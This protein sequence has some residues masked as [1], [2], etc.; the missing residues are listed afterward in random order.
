MKF[1]IGTSQSMVNTSVSGSTKTQSEQRL[2]EAWSV[3]GDLEHAQEIFT[4]Y[5]KNKINLED[6]QLYGLFL[7]IAQ[8]YNK[9]DAFKAS[10]AY[11]KKMSQGHDHASLEKRISNF[12]EQ[13]IAHTI[14]QGI[15]GP[16]MKARKTCEADDIRRKADIV[17]YA[18]AQESKH[19]QD[20]CIIDA[21]ISTN[22]LAL[23]EKILDT[24]KGSEYNGYSLGSIQFFADYENNH[25]GR[26]FALKFN[27]Q[28]SP[29]DLEEVMKY[30]EL[31][32]K[33]GM[34]D[35][36]RIQL[37]YIFQLDEQLK[38]HEALFAQNEEDLS[39]PALLGKER[40]RAILGA[41]RTRID[42]L[43]ESTGYEEMKNFALYKDDFEN[44]PAVIAI[45]ELWSNKLRSLKG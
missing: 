7:D 12:A 29:D 17:C 1:N 6:P 45:N 19:V 31:A 9:V 2:E 38:M 28:W 21:V 24:L 32:N 27:L 39:G 40:T 5:E 42:N 23:Q 3:V 18:D 13:G 26:L 36:S 33:M 43:K 30:T 22:A 8:K 25:V 10:V 11:G 14:T 44:H 15:L 41:W 20:P 4:R 16:D 37:L 35:N 34:F